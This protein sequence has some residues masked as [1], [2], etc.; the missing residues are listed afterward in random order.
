MA[1]PA[2]A[3]AYG[4]TGKAREAFRPRAEPMLTIEPP[5]WRCMCGI[6]HREKRN[7]L[8]RNTS[9]TSS[10]ISS[11]VSCKGPACNRLPALLTSTPRR[12]SV[13]SGAC[14]ARC[15]SASSVTLPGTASARPPA[16]VIESAISS[17]ISLRRPVVVT[18]APS[19]ANVVAMA[20]PMP[21]PPPVT[22]A[23]LSASRMEVP[24]SGPNGRVR[25]CVMLRRRGWLMNHETLGRDQRLIEVL[26]G[27]VDRLGHVVVPLGL[28][29]RALLFT[30]M[31][32]GTRGIRRS[33]AGTCINVSTY[34]VLA[35]HGHDY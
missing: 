9:N 19:R 34:N 27:Q 4:W 12:P 8:L 29:W 7:T 35:G 32:V 10:Q 24:R 22:M 23:T 17:R 26:L 15:T 21:V 16:A 33:H 6:T 2:F 20:A 14:T 31:V 25:L 30:R 5:P 28:I 3:T 13:A 1:T 18:L 11:A